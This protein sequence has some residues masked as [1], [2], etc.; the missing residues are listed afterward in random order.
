MRRDLKVL[1]REMCKEEYDNYLMT[2]DVITSIFKNSIRQDIKRKPSTVKTIQTEVDK[3]E[4]AKIKIA[5]VPLEENLGCGVLETATALYLNPTESQIK[6]IVDII[7]KNDYYSK[8]NG[9][10]WHWFNNFCSRAS[11]WINIVSALKQGKMT[12]VLIDVPGKGRMFTNIVGF[13]C[14]CV[15]PYIETYAIEFKLSGIDEYVNLWKL[16]EMLV[17]APWIW[18]V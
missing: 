12:T 18:N 5:G 2:Q 3:K 16:G 15:D 6:E 10:Y 17:T 9:L 7:E 14:G 11:H 1:P 4:Y 13:W 8:E